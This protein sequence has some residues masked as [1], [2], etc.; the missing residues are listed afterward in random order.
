MVKSIEQVKPGDLD[1]CLCGSGLPFRLCCKGKYKSNSAQVID[2]L[3]AEG[4]ADRA[5]ESTR[6]WLTWYRLCHIAHTEPLAKAG[7]KGIEPLLS[8]D[9]KALEEIIELL[10]QC[11]VAAGVGNN[12]GE[13]LRF[14]SNAIQDTRWH[15]SYLVLLS[16]FLVYIADDRESA[17]IEISK[18][19]VIGLTK[20]P[21]LLYFWL[22]LAP[23]EIKLESY[24]AFHRRVHSSTA[25]S[26]LHLFSSLG[27]SFRYIVNS[28]HQL[29][30]S[31][32]EKS[33]KNYK[34]PRA[35][36]ASFVFGQINL[37]FATSLLGG[38]KR[39]KGVAQAAIRC[40]QDTLK[41]GNR[42]TDE[43]RVCLLVDCGELAVAFGSLDNARSFF[44]AALSESKGTAIALIFLARVHIYQGQLDDSRICLSKAEDMAQS[45]ANRMDAAYVYAELALTSAAG[46]D[47]DLAVSKLNANGISVGCF[48]IR[49]L[50]YL[51]DLRDLR[52]KLSNRP[53]LKPG[54]DWLRVLKQYVMVEPNFAGFGLR[55]GNIVDD[56]TN[57]HRRLNPPDR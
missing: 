34:S 12:F 39:D 32:L 26:T 21:E 56:A 19:G 55:L 52:S 40:A 7:I 8:I 18:S 11:Y 25:D 43:Q 33:L 17:W 9:I 6:R 4:K 42:L 3:I 44:E 23:I 14:F 49:R 10:G 46:D 16:S 50:N 57:R 37:F 54:F 31:E 48:E 28:R 1:F 22:R 35:S 5:L 24:E 45:E 53:A 38:L 27:L 51:N 36:G 47:I 41:L 29:A 15:E 13:C 20:R 30:I 2:L